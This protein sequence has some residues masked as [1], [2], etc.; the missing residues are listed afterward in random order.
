MSLKTSKYVKPGRRASEWNL[1]A[2]FL[3]GKSLIMANKQRR[4]DIASWI[5]GD[6]KGTGSCDSCLQEPFPCKKQESNLRHCPSPQMERTMKPF[7]SFPLVREIGAISALR[8]VSQPF[9]SFP[10]CLTPCSPWK[11]SIWV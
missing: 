4:L 7:S 10:L 1:F 11:S 2:G 8:A 9:P 5:M 3:L 6:V